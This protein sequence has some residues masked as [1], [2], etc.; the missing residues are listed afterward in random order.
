MR[1]EPTSECFNHYSTGVP[2]DGEVIRFSVSIFAD[3]LS[4]Y[5][6]NRQNKINN[7]GNTIID[8]IFFKAIDKTFIPL[9][10]LCY[11]L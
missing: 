5:F 2:R 6:T 9:P 11:R 1:Y 4:D 10:E 8:K 7:K 3:L